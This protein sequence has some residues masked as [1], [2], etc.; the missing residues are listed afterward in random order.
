MTKTINTGPARKPRKPAAPKRSKPKPRA[1]KRRKA[2][3]AKPK[4]GIVRQRLDWRGVKL[5]V[6][7]DPA[8]F[9]SASYHSAHLEIRVLSPE[10]APL[11]IS[12]TGYRSHFLPKGY[13]A[14]AGGPA[15]Y[16][17]SWLDR[18]SSSPAYRRALD[19]WRQLDLFAMLK[20]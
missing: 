19:R 7:Y 12:D 20:S 16:V 18:E 5:T 2:R 6:T 9:P 11:P 15:D 8:Y 17:R 10:G 1:A 3:P 14:D 13:V 4:S